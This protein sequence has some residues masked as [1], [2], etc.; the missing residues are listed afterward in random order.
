MLYTT[1]TV[2]DID[3]KCRLNA[4]ACVDL[5]KKLGTNPLNLFMEIANTSKLPELNT[6][7]TILQA[8]LAQYQHGMTIDKTYELY[9]NFVDE[10][11]NMMD[12]IPVIM[13]VFK[14]SGFFPE[15]VEDEKN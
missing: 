13:D 10:G 2:K 14:V 5:E 8:S 9:D 4:R 3:Y 11:H 12:L 6:L 15:E 7:I 1:L